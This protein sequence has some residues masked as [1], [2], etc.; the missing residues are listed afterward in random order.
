MNLLVESMDIYSSW[1]KTVGKK[2]A[3]KKR[4]IKSR[5]KKEEKIKKRGR[6][7]GWKKRKKKGRKVK[8][9]F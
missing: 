5:M 8:D 2:S 7:K 6:E 1:P 4:G 3:F 9:F